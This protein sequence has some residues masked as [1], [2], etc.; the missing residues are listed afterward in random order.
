MKMQSIP[1]RGRKGSVIYSE[2]RHGKRRAR[3]RAPSQSAHVPSNRT[4]ATMSALFL[5]DGPL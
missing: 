5:P 4:T 3:V 2:T 1:K